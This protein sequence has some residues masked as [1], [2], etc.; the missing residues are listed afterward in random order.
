MICVQCGQKNMPTSKFCEHCGARLI[1]QCPK[2]GS[3]NIERKNFCPECGANLK[4]LL[5][6]LSMSGGADPKPA[7]NELD[8]DSELAM[9]KRELE[10]GS[11]IVTCPHCQVKNRIPKHVSQK[12]A[13]CGKCGNLLV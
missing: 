8:L 11:I 2:C 10:K 1:T 4:L 7:L 9:Y 12:T 3:R 5:F 6:N 13:R